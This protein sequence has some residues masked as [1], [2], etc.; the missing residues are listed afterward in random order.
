MMGQK[1]GRKWGALALLP[2]LPL[3]LLLAGCRMGKSLPF[4]RM[5]L[6][7]QF[8]LTVDGVRYVEDSD[9][10]RPRADGSGLFWKFTGKEGKAIGVCGG[11]NPER[12]GGYDV[13]P[14]E[15]D[16][17]RRFLYVRPNHFVFGPYVTYLCFR[18]DLP[19]LP[20]SAETVGLVMLILGEEGEIAAQVD[21][22]GKIAALM[23]AFDGDSVP[24]PE[25]ES[26]MYGSLLLCHR[27]Y[28]FLRCEVECCYLPEEGAAYCRGRSRE[29]LA[30]PGEWADA[31]AGLAE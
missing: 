4:Y 28:P 19:V 7:P 2:A 21:D 20:P 22:P 30:L 14:V 12:G 8:S 10:V 16:E 9:L 15:G 13:C 1:R 26:R 27:D 17:E 31:M 3:L 25:G 24:K 11:E 18:E 6:S 29:W 23:E 5:E